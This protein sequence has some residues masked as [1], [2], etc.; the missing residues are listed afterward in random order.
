MVT[1][2]IE[3][4]RAVFEPQGWHKLWALRNRLE[5]PLAHIT[6]VRKNPGLML[7][8]FDRLKVAGAHLP[9]LISAGTFLGADGLDFWDVTDPDR[10]II[11]D[12]QDE[13]YRRLVVEVE[14]A[15]RVVARLKEAAGRTKARSEK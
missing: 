3:G 1:V 15:D 12:L 13:T 4:D 10:A 2:T 14:D 11:V 5:I 7:G 9:S 8:W 6:G